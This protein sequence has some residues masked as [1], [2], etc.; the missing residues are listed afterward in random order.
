MKTIS[1][2]FMII[3]I[4]VSVL[5]QD[6]KILIGVDAGPSLTSIR[7]ESNSELKSKVGFAAGASFEY[8]LNENMGLKSGL[9]FEQKGAKDEIFLT[10][11]QGDPTGTQEIDIEYNYL[12][13]PLLF[14][15]HSPGKTS[16]YANAGPYLGL[17][18]SNMVYYEETDQAPGL[19]EDFTSETNTLDFGLSIGVGVNFELSDQL[20]FGIDVKENLGLSKT[21]GDSKTN[22]IGLLFG[23]KYVLPK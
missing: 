6:A 1:T 2:I 8:F 14:A 12:V 7:N 21:I 16:F 4:S 17:L 3:M 15:Y 18:L 5:A 9:L 13:L 11:D 10:D 23:I 22:S 20:L 19:K